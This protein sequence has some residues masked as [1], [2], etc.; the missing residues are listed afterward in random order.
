MIIPPQN[1]NI[2]QLKG[3]EL[4]EFVRRSIED[5][6]AYEIDDKRNFVKKIVF[7][8]GLEGRK[9]EA[10]AS[11]ALHHVKRHEK[12]LDKDEVQIRFADLTPEEISTTFIESF[13]HGP[14]GVA[15]RQQ[16]ELELKDQVLLE[17]TA[18]LA[19]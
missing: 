3:E 12:H 18:W 8:D 7:D 2:Y 5:N 16:L 9:L 19:E 14:E 15:R 1:E 17:K 11:Y 6:E 13:G 4:R 10:N